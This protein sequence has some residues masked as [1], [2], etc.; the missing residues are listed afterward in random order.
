MIIIIDH[1]PLIRAI[2]ET[3]SSCKLSNHGPPPSLLL[4][5]DSIALLFDK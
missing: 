2:Q 3:V 5:F 1:Y 4:H